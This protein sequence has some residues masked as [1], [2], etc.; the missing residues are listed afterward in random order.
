[1]RVSRLPID[2]GPAAWNAIVSRPEAVRVALEEHITADWIIVGA[3]F[4]GLTAACRLAELCPGDQIV[5]LEAS[6]VA[7][8]P[9]GR[10]S[11]FMIDV[12]HDLSSNDYGGNTEHD[13]QEVRLNRAGIAYAQSLC[14]RFEANKDAFTLSGK[15]N[16]AITHRGVQHN[17]HYAE[18]L[19]TLSEPYER[20]DSRQMH[21]L[22]GTTCYIDGLYTPG[23]AMIQPAMYICSLAAGVESNCVR[24]HEL[25]AVTE[26]KRTGKNWRASTRQGSVTAPKVILCV[27]G[28]LQS[29]GFL[30]RRLMH[31]F[32]Y[33]SMTRRM[34]KREVNAL[35]GRPEWGI[36]PADPL[37]TT[38][39]R[40]S[41]DGGDR[42][43]IRNRATFDPSM[44]VGNARI[45]TV[46]RTHDRSF[47]DRFPMLPKLEMEFR[48]GGRLCLSRNNVPVFGE[49][50]AGL[51]SACCQNGLGTVKGTISGKLI[52]E[53]ACGVQSELLD[54]MSVAVEPIKLPPEPLASFG[55]AAILRWGEYK[56]G[57][58]L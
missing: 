46:A 6:K 55:A 8:G 38:V 4:A 13:R 14:E 56:A 43:I 54:N 22:T 23:T 10:N 35:G 48:W 25:S 11:G 28:H 18:H 45:D 40:I 29:F 33:A 42:L 50:E 26:L 7:E 12:P 5:V 20:L 24:I 58:E 37:G 52:A 53:L 47:K 9:A 27:N 41:G 21:A 15:V 51:F 17:N 49:I 57:R 2:P 32:T 16:G 3:G 44:E 36:T 19:D 34:T 1:M 30:K 31:V 39:R